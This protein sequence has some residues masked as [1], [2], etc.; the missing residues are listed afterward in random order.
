MKV[1]FSY[2]ELKK[3]KLAPFQIRKESVQIHTM[4]K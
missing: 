4:R 2:Y 1:V 3:N